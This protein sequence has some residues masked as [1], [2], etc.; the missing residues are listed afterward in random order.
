MLRERGFKVQPHFVDY[1]QAAVE[2]EWIA[3]RAVARELELSAPTYA[4]L[5]AFGATLGF[6]LLDQPLSRSHDGR[7]LD[8]QN[9]FVPH[10]NLFL[11][12]CAA[13]TAADRGINAIALGIVGGIAPTYPDV[14]SRFVRRLQ[15]ILNLSMPVRVHAPFAAKT[16]YDVV[17]YGWERGFDYALTFSCHRKSNRHCG[18]CAGCLERNAALSRYPSLSPRSLRD[19][20][21]EL[22]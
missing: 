2:R 18:R 9:A 14:T 15:G 10:R 3:A 19:T 22:R 4:D 5:S 8:S 7:C 6:A 13:M 21:N 11:A 17:R 20:F 12:T 16:K 1:G